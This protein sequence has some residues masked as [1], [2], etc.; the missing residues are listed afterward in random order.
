[1]TQISYS[2]LIIPFYSLQNETRYCLFQQ[3]VTGRWQFIED[4]GEWGETPEKTAERAAWQA[5]GYTYETEMKPLACLHY[6]RQQNLQMGQ[7]WGLEDTK[8]PEYAFALRAKGEQIT[9]SP[10]YMANS[11]LDFSTA[12][13][14][15]QT[16]NSQLALR[17]LACCLA[18][19][20]R[21]G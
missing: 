14:L 5:A 2:V 6:K 19:E 10:A 3:A 7:G 13:S 18:K 9:L 1:M 15:L 12:M 4:S 17:E 21:N 20:K 8:I 16:Q 11:W